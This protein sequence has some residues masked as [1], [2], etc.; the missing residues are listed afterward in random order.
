MYLQM[1]EKCTNI[2]EY[3]YNK[4]KKPQFCNKYCMRHFVLLYNNRIIRIQKTYRGYKCRKKLKTIFYKLPTDIQKHIISF[5]SEDNTYNTYYNKL[6][7]I[8]FNKTSKL[9]YINTIPTSMTF[10]YIYNAYKLYVK[11]YKIIYLNDLKYVFVLS[12]DLINIIYHIFLEN[13]LIDYSDN[14]YKSI[15]FANSQHYY[16]KLLKLLNVY[17]SVYTKN[18]YLCP[19]TRNI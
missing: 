5:I 11:Y 1:T 8:I 10:G 16:L 7:T 12:E 14:I 19:D 2:S 13:N 6:R 18:F 3:N 15:D 17:N 9:Y 4:C